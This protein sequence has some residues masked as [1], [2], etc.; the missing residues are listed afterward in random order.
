MGIVKLNVDGGS[1]SN[2][3]MAGFGSLLQDDNGRWGSSF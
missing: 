2:P 1:R 3:G